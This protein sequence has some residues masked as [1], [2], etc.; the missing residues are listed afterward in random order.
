MVNETR[1]FVQVCFLISWR[2]ALTDVFIS[3]WTKPYVN[4]NSVYMRD[5]KQYLKARDIPMGKL[6]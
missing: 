4:T 2:T 6:E 1:H 3:I 5:G